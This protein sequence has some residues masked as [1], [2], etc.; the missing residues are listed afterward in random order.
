MIST[1]NIKKTLEE[2]ESQ[3]TRLQK[4]VYGK[5][6]AQIVDIGCKCLKLLLKLHSLFKGRP[7]E[8]AILQENFLGIYLFVHRTPTIPTF[9]EIEALG[10]LKPF[11]LQ[12]KDV[13][14]MLAAEAKQKN[15]NPLVEF[16]LKK[17]V[18]FYPSE[19]LA[20]TLSQ[21]YMDNNELSSSLGA[22]KHFQGEASPKLF[23]QRLYCL[24][25]MCDFEAISKEIPELDSLLD[26]GDDN[27]Y[28]LF[29]KWLGLDSGTVFRV[30][31]NYQKKLEG[32]QDFTFKGSREKGR[33]IRLA[34]IGSNFIPHAQS[35]QFGTSFFKDHSDKFELTIY[36]I[37]GQGTS[38]TEILFKDQVSRYVN[39]QDMDDEEIVKM[40]R[41]DQ[42]DIIVNG[43]GHAD[44][45]R[46]YNILCRR[47]APVQIDYLGYPGSSGATY[48]DYYV[49]DPT[50]T[51]P[52][53]YF[54]EKLILMPHTYQ[55]TEHA[56]VYP[57]LPVDKLTP[58]ET[59]ETMLKLIRERAEE[60]NAE[61]LE[62]VKKDII[63]EVRKIYHQLEKGEKPLTSFDQQ[64]LF[65]QKEITKRNCDAKHIAGLQ[66]CMVQYG[67][68]TRV[69]QG[70]KKALE[71]IYALYVNKLYPPEEFVK[72]RFIY[73]SLNHHV[74]LS[75]KDILTWNEILKQV[76]DSVLV[77]FLMFS[78]EPQEN[79]IKLFDPEVRDR[80]YFVGAAPKWLH[81]H[82]LRG[83]DCILDSF[84]YG[85]HTTAGDA[86]WSQVPIVTC[87]G[88]G[89][90]SR[91]CSSMLYAAG[92]EE[93]VT[94]D[95]DSYI[96]LAV[97]C[98]TDSDFYQGIKKKLEGARPSPLF[99]RKL[100][101]K[102]LT[103]GYEKAWERFCDGKPPEIIK[104]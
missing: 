26:Q 32:R 6:D 15:Q 5:N 42:I 59:Q 60:C 102:N 9:K 19:D 48:M 50:S 99:D 53:S 81:L 77:L 88:E 71:E 28:V 63:D 67:L 76:K 103:G 14:Y 100:Y 51:P 49:G 22:L 44:D 27:C 12:L 21:Y 47:V 70:D 34:Y 41:E 35:K 55:I 72:G 40:I 80:I 23:F 33:K 96:D 36:S 20:M 10:D 95:T 1:M 31:K 90:E 29:L 86:I 68:L 37:R 97:R 7:H 8:E 54:T 17:A 93:L 69:F 78:Y 18:E 92:I 104:F 82:R 64:V 91:V 13:H 62:F 58:K 79:L 73:C 46:P 43:N 75:R 38:N 66:R 85:A 101:V 98:A 83:I 24:N 25:K 52:G 61:I 84:Y 56:E 87:L 65:L 57:D 11:A 3:K 74:K 94:I 45:R 2:I 89:M 39:C 16:N 30:T 4:M